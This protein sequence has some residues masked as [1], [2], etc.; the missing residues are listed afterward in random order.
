MIDENKNSIVKITCQKADLGFAIA[1]SLLKLKSGKREINIQ[2]VFDLPVDRA[3]ILPSFFQLY[4]QVIF[5][6]GHT[7]QNNFLGNTK[8]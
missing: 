8:N 7:V 4:F 5:F 6:L 3:K 1:S 2:F